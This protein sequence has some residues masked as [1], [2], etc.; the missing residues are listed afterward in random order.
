V[1]D[2]FTPAQLQLLQLLGLA[3]EVVDWVIQLYDV[4]VWIMQLHQAAEACHDRCAVSWR[5]VE[6]SSAGSG[7]LKE[8]Q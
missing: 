4:D 3:P 6:S 2:P 5:L 8:E 7:E 1:G